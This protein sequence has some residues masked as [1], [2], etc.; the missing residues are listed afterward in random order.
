MDQSRLETIE[1]QVAKLESKLREWPKGARV[2]ATIE[3][4]SHIPRYVQ[5]VYKFA[6]LNNGFYTTSDRV[7]SISYVKNDLIFPKNVLILKI[8][9]TTLHE[10]RQFLR[11]IKAIVSPHS[12]S[13]VVVNA[14]I[15]DDDRYYGAESVIY[16]DDYTPPRKPYL[17]R[18]GDGSFVVS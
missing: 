11:D 17:L 10:A 16:A 2:E 8:A 13:R 6:D 7:D 4:T 12:G 14:K 15:V 1:R 18:Q 9:F 3:G 5:S